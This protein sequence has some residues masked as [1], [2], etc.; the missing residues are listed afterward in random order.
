M[1]MA[2]V[3]SGVALCGFRLMQCRLIRGRVS[4]V[5]SGEGCRRGG[6]GQQ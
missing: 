2:G 3:V 6:E 1:P 4:T 5:E